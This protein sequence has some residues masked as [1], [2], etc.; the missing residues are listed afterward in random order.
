[1]MSPKDRVKLNVYK[2]L[3][4]EEKKRNKKMVAV[5]A[6]LFVMGIFSDNVYNTTMSKFKPQGTEV[7]IAKIENVSSMRRQVNTYSV[8]QSEI[9]WD[10][11]FEGE[12]IEDKKLNLSTDELFVTDYGI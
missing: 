9:A 4:E 12:V 11:F 5:G 1:M 2:T 8:G 10:S 7:A 3:L 6:S